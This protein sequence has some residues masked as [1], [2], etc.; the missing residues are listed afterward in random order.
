MVGV[1]RAHIGLDE[2][3]AQCLETLGRP[4]QANLLSA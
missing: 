4:I 1:E 3:L 2:C